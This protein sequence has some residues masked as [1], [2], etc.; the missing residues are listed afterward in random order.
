MST[1]PNATKDPKSSPF[2]MKLRSTLYSPTNQSLNPSA[3]QSLNPLTSNLSISEYDAKKSYV[4]PR[5]SAYLASLTSKYSSPSNQGTLQQQTEE[6]ER[7]EHP[8]SSPKKRIQLDSANKSNPQALAS[9]LKERK[10]ENMGNSEEPEPVRP[11]NIHC[12]IT[13]WN[14]CAEIAD[15]LI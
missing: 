7:N 3:N 14:R 1:D 15:S 4:S 6:D 12:K 9:E 8:Q 13:L 2:G 5:N 11:N 10:I